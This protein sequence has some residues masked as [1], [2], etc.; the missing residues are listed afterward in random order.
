MCVSLRDSMIHSV[1]D[2]FHLC[3]ADI[4]ASIRSAPQIV[5]VIFWDFIPYAFV[6]AGFAGFV[7][8]N[9]GI[10]LGKVLSVYCFAQASF[11]AI[12]AINQTIYRPSTSHS[13]TT[14]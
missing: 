12:Q 10:V 5:P 11:M 13:Y 14:S 4:V 1:C 7:K 6:L 8:W 3:A 2:G 9:G